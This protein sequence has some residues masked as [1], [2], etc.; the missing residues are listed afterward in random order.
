MTPPQRLGLYPSQEEVRK[1]LRL[2]RIDHPALRPKQQ[3]RSVPLTLDYKHGRDLEWDL[4]AATSIATI[5]R[6]EASDQVQGIDED[7]GSFNV[8]GLVQSLRIVYQKPILIAGRNYGPSS[9]S[10]SLRS[11]LALFDEP[12]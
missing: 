10:T 3:D 12:W 11:A 4:A 7:E 1:D 8:A 2:D 5:R 6:G 9:A